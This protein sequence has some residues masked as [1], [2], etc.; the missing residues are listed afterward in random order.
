MPS[1]SAG[2]IEQDVATVLG[3]I[4]QD[5]LGEPIEDRTELRPRR[6][7][8]L[9]LEVVAVDRQPTI[10]EQ[11]GLRLQLLG[12]PRLELIL[13]GVASRPDPGGRIVRAAQCE[14]L[15]RRDQ[16]DE[17]PARVAMCS[18]KQGMDEQTQPK[19]IQ[20]QQ[21]LFVVAGD[22]SNSRQIVLEDL[23][24]ILQNPR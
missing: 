1:P 22:R 3:R 7:A 2:K 24:R 16:L 20:Q 17:L 5:D 4:V 21:A 11:R 12:D 14:L 8:Q 15:F 19:H 6:H 13:V 18:Q 23:R 10:D 9:V